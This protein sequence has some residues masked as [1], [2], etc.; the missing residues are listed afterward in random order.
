MKCK[1]GTDPSALPL[2]LELSSVV[3]RMM[4]P[5]MSGDPDND[6]DMM[7]PVMM[8]MMMFPAHPV[9]APTA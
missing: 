9:I 4:T 1:R 7:S 2:A 5:M 8:V 6:D 3:M